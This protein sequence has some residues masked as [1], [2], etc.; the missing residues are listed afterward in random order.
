MPSGGIRAHIIWADSRRLT[1]SFLGFSLLIWP[2][3][4]TRLEDFVLALELVLEF[5]LKVERLFLVDVHGTV[6]IFERLLLL[7]R[8][9]WSLG[10]NYCPDWG[11]WAW[12]V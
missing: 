3:V 10:H 6:A 5:V 1:L 11:T 8:V 2:A 9:R 7:L 4:Y 12:W